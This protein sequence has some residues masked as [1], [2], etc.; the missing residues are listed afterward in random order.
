MARMSNN[1][2]GFLMHPINE[3]FSY[4]EPRDIHG[5]KF[6]E[7]WDYSKMHGF[8]VLYGPTCIRTSY[9]KATIMAIANR[10]K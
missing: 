2:D 9:R 1:A 6:Y 7:L 5:R 4:T 3:R 8:G 10:T